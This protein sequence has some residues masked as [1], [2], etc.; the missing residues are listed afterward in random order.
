M[1]ATQSTSRPVVF[2]GYELPALM[3]VEDIQA[4]FGG[5]VERRTVVRWCKRGLFRGTKLGKT[6]VIPASTFVEDWTALKSG[7]PQARRAG[8]T[9][10]TQARPSDSGPRQP[11]ALAKRRAPE[12]AA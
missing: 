9:P 1:N 11:G 3:T 5:I 12:V 4:I 7:P 6:W 2:E 10:R 8:W